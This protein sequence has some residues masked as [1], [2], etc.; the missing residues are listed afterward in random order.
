MPRT[1]SARYIPR[2]DL[3]LMFKSRTI[4]AKTLK[5]F[6]KE[7]MKGFSVEERAAFCRTRSPV[8]ILAAFVRRLIPERDLPQSVG[9]QIE[10]EDQ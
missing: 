8:E 10:A 5:K 6:T 3:A 2:D 9:E 1:Q 4:D 7:F